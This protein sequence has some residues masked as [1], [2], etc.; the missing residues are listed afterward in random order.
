MLAVFAIGAAAAFEVEVAAVTVA[1]LTNVVS[2]DLL[3]TMVDT[4]GSTAAD[5]GDSTT[6]VTEVATT[7]VVMAVVVSDTEEGPASS[8]N[9]CVSFV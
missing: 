5:T 6:V 9:L 7:G 4:T 3:S 8:I 2:G 1:L